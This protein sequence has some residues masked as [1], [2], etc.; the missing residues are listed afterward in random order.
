M[1]IEETKRFGLK[2]L[3]VIHDSEFEQEALKVRGYGRIS[4]LTLN[5]LDLPGFRLVQSKET[6]LIPLDKGI[7]EILAGFSSTARNEIRRTMVENSPS[8]FD[9]SL[10]VTE[11]AYLLYLDFEKQLKRVMYPL[12]AFADCWE[13]SAR[14]E[15]KIVSVVWVYNSFPI[16]RVRHIFS[17]RHSDKTITYTNR[18]VM[19]EA[20]CQAKTMEC[21]ALDLAGIVPHSQDFKWS[22]HPTIARDYLYVRTSFVY[23]MMEKIMRTVRHL[24]QRNYKR[25]IILGHPTNVDAT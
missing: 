22:F 18:R 20:A 24:Q 5:K 6:G 14:R 13:V 9:F 23:G 1:K 11:E 15:G 8:I 19:F 17:I 10:H 3:T 21:S 16:A 2:T 25:R 12:T 4:I 7:D